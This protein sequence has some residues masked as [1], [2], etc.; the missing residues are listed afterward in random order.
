MPV[1]QASPRT[2]APGISARRATHG[3]QSPGPADQVLVVNGLRWTAI[4]CGTIL[5]KESVVKELIQNARA[6]RAKL[7][8]DPH[9]PAYHLV[10]P[11]GSRKWA[12][13]EQCD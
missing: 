7:L 3:S 8:A 12:A 6:L 13:G 10:A 5:A 9:R 1:W 4:W 2:R 11:E